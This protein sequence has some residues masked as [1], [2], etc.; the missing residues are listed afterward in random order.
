[1]NGVTGIKSVTI[2][3]PDP[4]RYA[5]LF[6]GLPV[7]YAG[8]NAPAIAAI[9]LRVNDRKAVADQLR[10]GGFSFVALKGDVLA[11]GADQAHGVLLVFD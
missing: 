6:D 5:R 4:A 1:M 9:R 10:K 7:A 8:A 2:A 11:V 3:T